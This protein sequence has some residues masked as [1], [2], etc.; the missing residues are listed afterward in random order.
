MQVEVEG[1][2]KSPEGGDNPEFK[3]SCASE[4]GNSDWPFSS[5][6]RRTNGESRERSTGFFDNKCDEGRHTGITTDA[7]RRK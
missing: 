6:E 7:M 1:S 5:T 2:E 4:H 3:G